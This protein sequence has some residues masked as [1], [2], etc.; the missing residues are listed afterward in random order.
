MSEMT[1][2]VEH[3]AE[4]TVY[5]LDFLQ[6]VY[7]TLIEP[8]WLFPAIADT[9]ADEQK[10]YFWMSF[11]AVSLISLLSALVSYCSSGGSLLFLPVAMSLQWV[12]GLCCWF[13]NALFLIIPAYVF[14]GHA[15]ARLYLILSGLS[16]LPLL[17]MSSSTLL[18]TGSNPLMFALSVLLGLIILAW[19][20][21]LTIWAIQT[22]YKFNLI[23]LV[24]AVFLPLVT[25]LVFNVWLISGIGAL[26]TLYLH[27]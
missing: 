16:T 13:L 1:D 22:T 21:G 8:Q 14:T 17:F 18:K 27:V 10:H 5:K 19:M 25:T 15:Q 4:S 7:Y 6:V 2:P 3:A 26:V 20:M 9:P 11:A 12:A 24:L 23:Q